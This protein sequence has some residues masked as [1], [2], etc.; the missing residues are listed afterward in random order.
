ML[1]IISF[2]LNDRLAILALAT[3][4]F[5][6]QT[7]AFIFSLT[8]HRRLRDFFDDIEEVVY[9]ASTFYLTYIIVLMHDHYEEM[10][11]D[12]PRFLVPRYVLWSLSMLAVCSQAYRKQQWWPL[13]CIPPFMIIL[14]IM[15]ALPASLTALF[16]IITLC[17]WLCRSLY[18]IHQRTITAKFELSAF[19]IKQAID[20]LDVGVLFYSRNGEI[21][22]NNYCMQQLML[23]L[24]GRLQRNGV[25]FKQLLLTKQ[26]RPEIRV[27]EMAGDTIF[28]L[29][30]QSYWL[31]N[32]ENLKV[33]GKEY[34]QLSAIDVTQQ[35]NL[36]LDLQVKERELSERGSQL[37]T[38]LANIESIHQEEEYLNIKSKVHDIMAQ[39]LALLM[40]VLRGEE[41]IEEDV[42]MTY[43]DSILQ[44]IWVESGSVEEGIEALI[45]SYAVMGVTIVQKGFISS[46]PSQA[47]FVFNFLREGI[48]NAVR[49]GFAT[50]ITVDYL[51][52]ANHFTIILA[53]NGF[54]PRGRFSEGGGLSDL[55]RRLH[56]LD[57]QL[58]IDS[59]PVFTL[60]AI[61][62]LP[63]EVISNA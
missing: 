5:V 25:Q 54:P 34:L 37:K 11:F 52:E 6:A 40:R 45:Q 36:T 21:H 43:A 24:T 12:M 38:A 56:F 48:A 31:F 22:I 27:L 61:L 60:K 1:A 9:L 42:L 62:P 59:Q 39:R 53:N 46:D 32:E 57:G 15:D 7:A 63:K 23:Q 19:S 35:T 58:E 50:A 41:V 2:S 3:L 14:P 8:R 51:W 33:R 47:S 49:H 28:C 20:S 13:L 55:R 4:T 10:L 30:D 29:E 44:D 18:L 26:I 17:W 16:L